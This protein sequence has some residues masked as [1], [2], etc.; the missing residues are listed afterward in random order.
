MTTH[1]A[2]AFSPKPEMSVCATLHCRHRH[3]AVVIFILPPASSSCTTTPALND[4]RILSGRID[5]HYH[6]GGT[7]TCCTTIPRPSTV[8]IKHALARLFVALLLVLLYTIETSR[9]LI[10]HVLPGPL[11]RFVRI[12]SKNTG[13]RV[14]VLQQSRASSCLVLQEDSIVEF[15]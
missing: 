9:T 8:G 1:L 10:E 13:S 6:L 15:I 14:K 11:F 2:P 4:T 7:R 12:K 3:L 5:L